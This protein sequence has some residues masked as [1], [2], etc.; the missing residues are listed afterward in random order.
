MKALITGGAGFTP[1]LPTEDPEA[2]WSREEGDLTHY[3]YVLQ[4]LANGSWYIGCTSDLGG[5]LK[6]HRGGEVLATKGKGPWKLLYYE[7]YPQQ[8]TAY[9]RE[10]SLKRFGGA[11]RQLKLRLRPKEVSE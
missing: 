2:S 1:P 6:L 7:V 5:R 8:T 11:Y 4:S 3:V 9:R 10:Q